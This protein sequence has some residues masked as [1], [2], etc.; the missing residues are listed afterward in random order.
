MP[1]LRR[2]GIWPLLAGLA[3]IVGLLGALIAWLRVPP[4]PPRLP[5]PAEREHAVEVLEAELGRMGQRRALTRQDRNDVGN[6]AALQAH[7]AELQ[8]LEM[9]WVTLPREGPAVPV[10]LRLPVRGEPARLPILIEGLHRQSRPAQLRRVRLRP[11][12]DALIAE[13]ELRFHRPPALDKDSLA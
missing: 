6:L 4:A 10:E 13:L 12:G 1:A 8:L 3:L 9:S 7:A 2:S 11:D 5:S